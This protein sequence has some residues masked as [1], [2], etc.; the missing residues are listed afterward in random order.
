MKWGKK[1]SKISLDIMSQ[2]SSK[3]VQ[4]R[5]CYVPTVA[6]G[7]KYGFHVLSGFP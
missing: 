2:C 5:D 4:D 1:L 3:S 7:R 6:I